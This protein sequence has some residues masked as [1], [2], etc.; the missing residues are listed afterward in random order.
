MAFVVYERMKPTYLLVVL[1]EGRTD[2]QR[3]SSKA[4]HLDVPFAAPDKPNC[5]V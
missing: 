5:A 4:L 3:P 2:V 1:V